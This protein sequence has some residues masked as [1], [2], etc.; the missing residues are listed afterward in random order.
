MCTNSAPLAGIRPIL[1]IGM[2]KMN[3]KAIAQRSLI[4]T[5]RAP[6]APTTRCVAACDQPN[7][8]LLVSV[9]PGVT[10]EK[11]CGAS[12]DGCSRLRLSLSSTL[13]TATCASALQS[14][15]GRSGAGVVV[16]PADAG[17]ECAVE[18]TGGA[19]LA[20]RRRA[21]RV[22]TGA[23]GCDD[24]QSLERVPDRYVITWP[25]GHLALLDWS[26]R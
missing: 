23:G 13:L 12:T 9:L 6:R 5:I 4:L 15:A 19:V 8:G 10:P 3:T 20:G 11:S 24:P 14:S 1:H 16:I 22:G 7:S 2:G 17:L 26:Q 25:A 18:L 21:A